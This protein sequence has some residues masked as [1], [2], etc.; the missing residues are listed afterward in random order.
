VARRFTAPLAATAAALLLA[1]CGS[2]QSHDDVVRA[3]SG[4]GQGAAATGNGASSTGIPG[5]DGGTQSLPGGPAAVEGGSAVGGGGSLNGGTTQSGG[6]GPGSTGTKSGTPGGGGS[7]DHSPIAIGNVGNYSGVS[8]GAQAPGMIALKVFVAY[9]NAHGGINGHPIK[10]YVRDD[11]SNP[12]QNAAAVQQLVEQAHV[13]AFVSNWSS[14]TAQAS[15]KYLADNH[16]PVIG[17][18][19]TGAGSWGVYY[20]F[21][22]V[23]AVTDSG[24]ESGIANAAHLMVPQG[25]TKLGV[26]VCAEAPNIC[27]HGADVTS[28]YAPKVGFTIAY[29]QQASFAAGQY[30]ANCLDMQR[31]GVQ[32]VEAIMPA[33]AVRNIARDCAQQGFHPTYM[34]ANGTMEGDFNKDANFD[35]AVVTHAAYP[36]SGGPNA[37]FQRYAAA[38]KQYAPSQ[39]LNPATSSGWGAALMFEAAVQ[40]ISGPVTN[41]SLLDTLWSFK[42]FSPKGWTIPV[43]YVKNKPTNPGR[44]YFSGTIKNGQYVVLNNGRYQCAS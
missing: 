11:Q 5:T 13:V 25:K 40:K 30:T 18:D 31:N 2:L 23:A 26:L 39:I 3:A 16:I 1:G 34:L 7:A 20:N 32:V 21:F 43:T 41:T 19:H 8:G 9:V 35:G 22:P 12:S 4:G 24:V 15:A 17:G 10:L 29:N 36:F 27:A 37:E 14:Q 6:T 38:F 33:S 42:N 28:A 44:C